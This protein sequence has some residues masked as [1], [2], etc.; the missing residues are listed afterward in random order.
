MG[1]RKSQKT[2]WNKK[3]GPKFNLPPTN[4][5]K[6]KLLE[7]VWGPK[8]KQEQWQE[9]CFI[10]LL[11]SPLHLPTHQPTSREAWQIPANLS[12]LKLA[13]DSFWDETRPPLCASSTR[14]KNTPCMVYIYYIYIY[15]IYA[16]TYILHSR[17]SCCCS[18]P[19]P[20]VLDNDK[21]L[22]NVEANSDGFEPLFSLVTLWLF[23]LKL[24]TGF[25]A[26]L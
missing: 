16:Q 7:P 12:D 1:I 13:S 10:Q 17:Y 21:E 20:K 8:K 26:W 24:S 6:F 22:A 2:H 19:F 14:T 4:P 15:Y 11:F 9:P 18:H 3:G 25:R 23:H 5:S